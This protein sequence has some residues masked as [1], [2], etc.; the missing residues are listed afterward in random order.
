MKSVDKVEAARHSYLKQFK[1]EEQLS[2][3][4]S[5]DDLK[6]SKKLVELMKK[7]GLTYNEAYA[8]LQYAHNLLEY[9]SNFLQF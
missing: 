5:Q 6:I 3:F 8:S 9:E 1:N 7:E 4:V 2:D